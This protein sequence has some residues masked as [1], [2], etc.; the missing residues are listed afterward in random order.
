MGKVTIEINKRQVES[1]IE[2]FGITDKLKLVKKLERET[3]KER[4]SELI[5]KI[6]KRYKKNPISD[7]EIRRICKEVR[8]QRYERN[9]KGS[10]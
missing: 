1:I 3:R 2:Q 4:W 5:S 7:E 6:R 10:N 8:R 9:T